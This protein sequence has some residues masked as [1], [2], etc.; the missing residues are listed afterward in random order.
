MSLL[1]SI[2][3]FKKFLFGIFCGLF[4]IF[5]GSLITNYLIEQSNHR[6]SKIYSSQLIEGSI[7]FIGNSRSVPFNSENLKTSKK[8]LNL[9]QNSMNSFEVENIIKAIKK[10]KQSKKIIY[11]ELTSLVDDSIQCQYSIFYDLKFYFGKESIQ[12]ECKI[13][14]FLENLIP[15][16]KI[17][18]ELFYRIVYYYFFP[19]KDQQWTNQYVMPNTVCANPKTNTLIDH[20]FSNDSKKKMYKKSTDLLRAYSDNN[21]KIFFFIAPIYQKNNLALF[22]EEEF[23]QQKKFNLIKLNTLLNKKFFDDCNMFADTLHLSTNGIKFIK[24]NNIFFNKL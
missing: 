15:I 8:I 16:A 1:L 3:N 9:S 13:V 4:M 23:L 6:L 7:F 18:N 21:T 24:K 20:F 12:R 10:K 22:T 19:E 14:L 2:F 11:I 5:L 17:N